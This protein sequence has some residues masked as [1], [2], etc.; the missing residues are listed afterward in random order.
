MISRVAC[1]VAVLTWAAPASASGLGV[2]LG[3]AFGGRSFA[4]QLGVFGNF[5]LPVGALEVSGR[6][7]LAPTQ[8]F[9]G[10]T[11]AVRYRTPSVGPL[12]TIAGG[13]GWTIWSEC[14]SGDFCLGL[15]PFVEVSPT[16]EYRISDTAV[17]QLA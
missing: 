11:L 8:P 16:L 7:F 1:V 4:A 3:P 2:E 15:G 6:Y 10:A 12:F 14:L 13:L 9:L 5:S 17:L